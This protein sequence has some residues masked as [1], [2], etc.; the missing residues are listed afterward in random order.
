MR[1]EVG[2]KRNDP[3]INALKTRL[4]GGN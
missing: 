3:A 4:T 1:N 2:V